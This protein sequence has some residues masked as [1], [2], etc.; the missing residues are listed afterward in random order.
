MDGS[1]DLRIL[2]NKLLYIF[3][4]LY[5]PYPSTWVSHEDL[6]K[7]ASLGTSPRWPE[8]IDGYWWYTTCFLGISLLS[9][10][11][12]FHRKI[13]KNHCD[14]GKLIDDPNLFLVTV[15]TQ[16]QSVPFIQII[17]LIPP[18]ISNM[19]TEPPNEAGWFSYWNTPIDG[20]L[21]ASHVRFP[22]SCFDFFP[23]LF[24]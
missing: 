15:I 11:S 7:I 10:K 18:V 2:R 4:R 5:P 13:M 20:D 9:A 16:F 21:P 8:I 24:H 17:H 12:W 23:M 19:A 22:T 6:T 1:V 14:P 3:F